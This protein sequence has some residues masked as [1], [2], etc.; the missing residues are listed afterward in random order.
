MSEPDTPKKPVFNWLLLVPPV[1]FLAI[2]LAFYAGLNRESPDTLPSALAGRAAP[3][4]EL[5][6]LDP[7]AAGPVTADLSKPGI[8]LVNFWASWCAPCRAEHPLL[9]EIA[10]AG[11]PIIGVN[12]KDSADNARAFLDELGDPFE[13]VG[14]DSAGRTAINWGL[15]GV[16]ETF[17]IDGNGHVLLR[18]AGPITR[19]IY[20]QRFAPLLT[21]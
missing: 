13:S 10:E 7:A 4:L 11:T 5:P 18:H 2:A 17:V 14:T 19:S 3:A 6:P 16:P 21:N 20:D 9:T 15:Y 12:Y 1:V 8:K